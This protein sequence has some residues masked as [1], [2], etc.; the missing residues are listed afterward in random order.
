MPQDDLKKLVE[1]KECPMLFRICASNIL[2]K[3]GFEIVEKM[4]DRAIGKPT[5]KTEITGEDSAP[6]DFTIKIVQ[7]VK[8]LPYD[9]D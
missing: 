5:T 2:G 6:I 8:T 9:P 4:L 1:D 3:K 7:G